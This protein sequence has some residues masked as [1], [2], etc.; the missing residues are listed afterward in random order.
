LHYVVRMQTTQTNA[1]LTTAQDGENRIKK[2]LATF[3][4]RNAYIYGDFIHKTEMEGNY[5]IEYLG[6]GNLDGKYMLTIESDG[7]IDDDLSKL[8]EILFQW[9][10]ENDGWSEGDFQK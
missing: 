2:T 9:V 8:E 6:E 4:D 3:G 7:W 1:E 10:K 5:H